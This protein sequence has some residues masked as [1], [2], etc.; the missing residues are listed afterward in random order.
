MKMQK[1]LKDITVTDSSILKLT[2]LFNAIAN[3]WNSTDIGPQKILNSQIPLLV[4]NLTDA[5]E[6]LKADGIGL[7]YSKTV[8]DRRYSD[9]TMKLIMFTLPKMISFVSLRYIRW[10]VPGWKKKELRLENLLTVKKCAD[11]AAEFL[12]TDFYSYSNSEAFFEITQTLKEIVELLI[13]LEHLEFI[14]VP[15]FAVL[16]LI[17]RACDKILETY[18]PDEQITA[19]SSLTV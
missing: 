15:D 14:N 13:I 18:C 9:L 11:Q 17:Q 12:D 5:V 16:V 19:G 6:A 4:G 10:I 7:K 2:E 3:D 8:K 1:K